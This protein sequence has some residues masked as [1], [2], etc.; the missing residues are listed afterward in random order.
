MN[1]N[2]NDATINQ[3]EVD[4]QKTANDGCESSSRKDKGHAFWLEA[5]C[6]LQGH[7]IE[8]NNEFAMTWFERSA[9]Q[10]QPKA[11]YSL[12]CMYEDGVGVRINKTKALEYFQRASNLGEPTAQYK[13]AKYYQRGGYQGL[14]DDG[15]PNA[16]KAFK[17]L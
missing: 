7:G 13:L 1:R 11:M 9:K 6:L 3:Q 4:N 16:A 12:G 14:G 15:K 8:P 5:E 10:G 17:L 2:N